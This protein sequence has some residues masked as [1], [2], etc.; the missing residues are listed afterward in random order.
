MRDPYAIL[1]VARTASKDEIKRAY[2][3]LAKELH[4]DV[5]PDDSIVE[6]RFKEVTAA[7]N[8]LSD[9]EKRKEFDQGQMNAGGGSAD[10][11]A[12]ARS[13]RHAHAS[14]RG[15]YA[16]VEPEEAENLFSEIFGRRRDKGVNVKG[17]NVGYTVTVSFLEAAR[18]AKKRIELYDGKSLDVA[19][20]AGCEDGQTLRLKGQGTPGFGAG[21]SGDAFVEVNVEPHDRFTRKGRDIHIQIP[22][23]LSEAVQGARIRVPSIDGAVD[24][25]VPAGS[26]TGTK[27][28]LKGKG[29][30]GKTFGG[31]G[32][33]YVELQVVLPPKPDKDLKAFVERW[34]PDHPYKVR[35]DDE[36]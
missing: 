2:R 24:L 28:R 34:A 23:S 14:S 19:V 4:P 30:P 20:P 13:Q 18:G 9:K 17:K 22:V 11:Q 16:G 21:R 32:D 27:L 6:Q 29:L 15:G 7:Y 35:A 1:G 10:R 8:L 5:N 25:T 12:H 3:K 31:R 33:Q 36:E 26:N